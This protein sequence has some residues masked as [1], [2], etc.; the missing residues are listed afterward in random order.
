MAVVL[1]SSNTHKHT[2]TH[3]CTH[4]HTHT[5][6]HTHTHT[7]THAGH[8]A[9]TMSK[10]AR[11]PHEASQRGESLPVAQSEDKNLSIVLFQVVINDYLKPL[12]R[13]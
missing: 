6:T 1:H 12:N 10:S 9:I 3:T 5:N 11:A 4:T 2:H 13:V 7:H 8:I